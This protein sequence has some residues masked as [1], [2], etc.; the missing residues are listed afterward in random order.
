M[1]GENF[2]EAILDPEVSLS[3]SNTCI[4]EGK[5]PAPVCLISVKPDN[6]DLNFHF[7][8]DLVDT[9]D[10]N[11]RRE[12]KDRK[13]SKVLG[14]CHF[15]DEQVT[16]AAHIKDADG[17]GYVICVN[18]EQPCIMFMEGSLFRSAMMS[19]SVTG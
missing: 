8:M 10:R 5:A 7:E 15:F 3:F 2:Q 11:E 12:I 1:C 14:K 16:H 6:P 4:E 17:K 18:F 19:S 9:R 13:T